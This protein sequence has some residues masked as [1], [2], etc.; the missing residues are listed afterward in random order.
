[1]HA[2]LE[3]EEAFGAPGMEPR[4][5]GSEKEAVGTAYNTA[6]RVW[7]TLARGI[8]TEIY[9]PTVDSPQVRDLQ[10]LVT[11]GKT[12]CHDEKWDLD[13]TLEPL[14]EHCLGYRVINEDRER[15]YRLVHQI[16]SDPHLPCVLVHTRLEGRP[17]FLAGLRVFA[18]V[19]PHLDMGGMGNTAFRLNASGCSVL[20][21]S[22]GGRHLAVGASAPFKVTSCGYVGA[23]D[24][25]TD[26]KKHLD[27]TWKFGHARNGNVAMTAEIDL[28]KGHEFTLGLAFGTRLHGA[29][30]TLFESLAPAFSDQRERFRRQWHGV[31]GDILDLE[32][33]AGDGGRLYRASHNLLLAHEDKTYPGA[34]I[35]SLSIPWGQAHGDEDGLGGYHL[36]W[37]RDLCQSAGAMIATGNAETPRRSLLYLAASQLP[38]GGFYQNFWINGDP[39]WRGRQLDETAFPLILAW[40]LD[41]LGALSGFS[42]A[43][44]MVERAAGWLM[45][46]GPATQQE[47]WEENAGYSP[48]TLAAVISGL[49]C[50]ADILRRAG[51]DAAGTFIEEYADFIE[52][53]LED[54]TVTSQGSLLPGVR[55]HYIRILPV[56]PADPGADED[57]DGAMLPMRNVPPGGPAEV[58]ARDVVDAGFL[59]LVRYGIRPAGDSLIEDSL[60]VV[61]A[62]LKCDTPL[63]PCWRRYNHDGYGQRPDGG[64]FL[65]WGRGRPWPI[66]TGERG[67]YEL[68]AGRDPA[69]Y[70][71]AL[72]RFATKT[73]MLPEQIWDE[74]DRPEMGLL[75][76]RPT[77]AAMPL[78]WAHAEYVKLLRS[79]RDGAVF[80]RLE[81][82]ARRYLGKGR[83]RELEIW[84]FN[85][86]SRTMIA[87][88]TLRVMAEA[89]FRLRWS[90][91]AWATAQETEATATRFGVR[92]V[93]V[94]TSR[95]SRAPISFTFLWTD[96]GRWEGRDYRVELAAPRSGA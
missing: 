34:M 49:V 80:D 32:E 12:F 42:P 63:G 91:D 53:R 96:G 13:S 73:G 20:A 41:S 69:L 70:L 55:R 61:D 5:T 88:R 83:R 7:F 82:V 3:G 10:F 66:L 75:F 64:P 4:W 57:P 36:V 71:R 28:S 25:W 27:M 40:R 15:R 24:G 54:W 8:L 18:L 77:G 6:S 78:L 51:D 62:T 93:D 44:A 72:E 58:P 22:K 1:M 79:A 67:H 35:A 94:P 21:A 90:A 29:V 16:I 47:R 86:R 50:A 19:A 43:L 89:P 76:G 65:G 56:D 37:T 9:F 33:R 74:A 60:R 85:R 39:Y 87:G 31:C 92:Y 59:E 52:S 46:E 95:E 11:D 2:V 23:S 48:S 38:D 17:E 30:T 26:L 14:D 45:R 81:P 84:K 68:A